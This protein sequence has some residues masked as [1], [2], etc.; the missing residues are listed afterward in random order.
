MYLNIYDRNIRLSRHKDINKF[1]TNSGK[2]YAGWG[3]VSQRDWIPDKVRLQGLGR[4]LSSA[5][6][7]CDELRRLEEAFLISVRLED[8]W[9]WS[10][11]T[12]VV[13]RRARPPGRPSTSVAVERRWGDHNH[14]VDDRPCLKT[15][16]IRM[17]RKKRLWQGVR[18]KAR[19]ACWPMREGR[20]GNTFLTNTIMCAS[21]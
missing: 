19:Q 1:V 16:I 5:G 18:R 11:A 4:D 6:I 7:Y 12:R 8:I 17:M 15:K 20:V 2:N 9:R 14:Y 3:D 21:F 10:W 13:G